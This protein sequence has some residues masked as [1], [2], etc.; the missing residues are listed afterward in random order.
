MVQRTLHWALV[1]FMAMS[2]LATAQN[3]EPTT[4]SSS[5]ESHEGNAANS[6]TSAAPHSSGPTTTCPPNTPCSDPEFRKCLKNSRD[7]TT[8]KAEYCLRQSN[9]WCQRYCH[10]DPDRAPC[11]AVD[12]AAEPE[13]PEGVQ[14]CLREAQ[15]PLQREKCLK[16][17]CAKHPDDCRKFCRDRPRAGLCAFRLQG[18]ERHVSLEP[19]ADGRGFANLTVNGRLVLV[20]LRI[21]TD[22]EVTSSRDADKTI[23]HAGESVLVLHDDASGFLRFEG[24]DAT[25]NLVFPP[26][27]SKEPIKDGARIHYADGGRS[28]LNSRNLTWLDDRTASLTEFFSFH[29]VQGQFVAGGDP[30]VRAKIQG[31]VERGDKVGAEIRINKQ[32]CAEAGGNGDAHCSDVF[33]YDR[34]KVSVK[35]AQGPPTV[36]DPLRIVL[37]SN[38]TEGRTFVVHINKTVLDVEVGQLRLRYFDL[39]D[40]ENGTA[41]T[42]II[43]QRAS[44]IEDILDP[45]D[46]G[47]QPEYWVVRDASGLQVLVS[48]PH[49]SV[50]LVELSSL[51]ELVQPS[52]VV[53]LVAG[54]AGIAVAAVALFMPRRRQD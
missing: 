12:G 8:C 5:N 42:E 44:S 43:F 34:V 28:V 6:T 36:S 45:S 48:V 29:A 16:A 41:K 20:S 53:G 13:G 30:A 27:I 39:P 49:W 19:M 50:H 17:Y 2:G 21:E 26:G 18:N 52:V 24:D 7:E 46:D 37:S 54:A 25:V 40:G 11:K 3:G 35:H 22:A 38:L 15:G 31:A 33:A 47:G 10:E 23:V 4:S 14:R 32:E 9:A 1:A 51:A